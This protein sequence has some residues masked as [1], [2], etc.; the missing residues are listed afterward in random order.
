MFVR[1]PNLHTSRKKWRNTC[2]GLSISHGSSRTFMGHFCPQE[3][4]QLLLT[5]GQQGMV[6]REVNYSKTHSGERISIQ[7]C[8][9]PGRHGWIHTLRSVSMTC[10]AVESYVCFWALLKC[11]CATGYFQW[12]SLSA[13]SFSLKSKLKGIVWLKGIVNIYE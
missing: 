9:K 3:P 6:L 7:M 4:S 10:A 13:P 2:R 11:W 8:L 1:S 5:R 12:P